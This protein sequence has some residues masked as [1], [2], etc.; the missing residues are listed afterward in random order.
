ME[1]ERSANILNLR[2]S[3]MVILVCWPAFLHTREVVLSK[4]I[5]CH[6]DES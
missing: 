5:E 6:Q 2:L 4:D 1:Q 3:I